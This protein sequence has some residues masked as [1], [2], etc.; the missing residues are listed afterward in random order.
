MPDYISGS[1]GDAGGQNRPEDVRTVYALFNKMLSTP[2]EVSDH[3]SAELIRA[4]RDFQKTFWSRPDGRIDVNGRT[5]RKLLTATDEPATDIS[6]SV[7]EGGQNRAKDVRIIYALLNKTLPSPLEVL[8]H[9]SAE[10][11]QAIK[12]FQKAFMSRPDGRIDVGGGTWRRLTAPA[13]ETAAG[14]SVILS[15]DDGPA[16]LSSLRSILDTLDSYG[17]KAEFYV[18]GQEVDNSPSAVKEIADRGH[19]VQNHSYTHPDLARASK[20]VVRNEL[21][22]TQDSIK[23]AAGVTATRIR[24]PYGAGGWRPYDADLAAVAEE[25]SLSILNWDIDTEDWKS[26]KGVGS[27]KWAMIKQQFS[28]NQSKS[29]FNVLMHVKK[30]TAASL[31]DFIDQLKNWGFSFARP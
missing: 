19:K 12:D 13:G 5:W 7:G 24:P 4:I 2:L 18:L 9:I 3:C 16:P 21:T 17:I 22:K 27:S 29:E 15:F 28:R 23:K 1:V 14:K 20:S 6:G 30:E 10:L 11:M 26:P 25:L 31:G 8:D